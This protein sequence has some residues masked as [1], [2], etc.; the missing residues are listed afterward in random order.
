MIGPV[1]ENNS[2]YGTRL[3]CLLQHLKTEAQPASKTLYLV[4]STMG[5]LQK[6]EAVSESK[7]LIQQDRESKY[8][9]HQ[10][11]QAWLLSL[12]RTTE[13]NVIIVSYFCLHNLISIFKMSITIQSGQDPTLNSF[14]Y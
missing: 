7:L 12:I 13:N 14:S 2:N 8:Q 10:K 11:S 3:I 4:Y 6:E 9:L 1:T 5:K